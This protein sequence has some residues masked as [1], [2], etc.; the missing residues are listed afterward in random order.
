MK[1]RLHH[2]IS[3]VA[4]DVEHARPTRAIGTA[5]RSDD[6]GR[7]LHRPFHRL[8]DLGETAAVIAGGDDGGETRGLFAGDVSD[9]VERINTQ[10]H[11]R[12]A[13]TKA[14]GESPGA[15]RL[16]SEE[17]AVKR[18]YFTDLS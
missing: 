16:L 3:F 14:L 18:L 7:E 2:Q 10:I 11:Q 12:S 4:I 17:A 6:A 13:T 5:A 9:R 1:R 8:L 15:G